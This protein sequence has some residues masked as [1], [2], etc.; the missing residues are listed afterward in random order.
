MVKY[1]SILPVIAFAAAMPAVDLSFAPVLTF[2]P[3]MSL[4]SVRLADFNG[5]HRPDVAV[6]NG[7]QGQPGEV[8]VMLAKNGGGSG[9]AVTPTGGYGS[10]GM[11]VADFNHDGKLDVAVTN[12]LSGNISI[13]LGNGDGTF[14]IAGYYSGNLSPTAIVAADFNHDGHAD[15]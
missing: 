3:G 8:E 5:D 15:L 9:P 11:A 2:Q 14:R 6:L 12:N 7:Q 4:R 1:S 13:M 10:W